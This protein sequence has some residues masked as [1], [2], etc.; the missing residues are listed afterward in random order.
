MTP[1]GAANYTT[2]HN[3]V[4]VALQPQ[5]VKTGEVRVTVC[6]LVQD[7]SDRVGISLSLSL[8]LCLVYRL[9][10]WKSK[11][12]KAV[13]NQS[14]AYIAYTLCSMCILF[15]QQCVAYYKDNSYLWVTNMFTTEDINHL[16]CLKG[17]QKQ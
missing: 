16:M 3:Q 17:L 4:Q 12:N 9:S 11:Q 2:S 10:P 13:N 14:K 6:G 8:S 5:V 15:D 1:S 7:A